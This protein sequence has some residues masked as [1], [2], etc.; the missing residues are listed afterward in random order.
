MKKF[1]TF[2]YIYDKIIAAIISLILSTLIAAILIVG[3]LLSGIDYSYSVAI[4]TSLV[5]AVIFIFSSLF[6]WF[7]LSD[8][9][10]D[11]SYLKIYKDDKYYRQVCLKKSKTL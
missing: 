1:Y 6:I 5:I 8:K 11:Y 10:S 3:V 4:L 7:Y 9:I 2:L